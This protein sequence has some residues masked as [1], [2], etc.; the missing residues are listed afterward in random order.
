[1]SSCEEFHV[2]VLGGVPERKCSRQAC[3]FGRR[4]FFVVLPKLCQNDS[5]LH[6]RCLICGMT[7]FAY[8][9]ACSD[10]S[11]LMRFFEFCLP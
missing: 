1:M 7:G 11:L 6:P 9:R 5:W 3:C 2:T 4:F 10:F 8:Q